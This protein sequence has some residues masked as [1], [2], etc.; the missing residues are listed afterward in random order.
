[1][2]IGNGLTETLIGDDNF[3]VVNEEIVET[4]NENP[5]ANDN[6]SAQTKPQKTIPFF[7]PNDYENG[8]IYEQSNYCWSQTRT[9]V[10]KIR[11][12]MIW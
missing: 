4:T 12:S 9:E 2:N 5:V 8:A 11:I 6:R 3:L 10:G 7:E 1:M